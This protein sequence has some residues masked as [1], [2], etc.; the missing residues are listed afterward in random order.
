MDKKVAVLY[1]SP[2]F[3]TYALA[4]SRAGADMGSMVANEMYNSR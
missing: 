1:E 4:L 3:G 2:D